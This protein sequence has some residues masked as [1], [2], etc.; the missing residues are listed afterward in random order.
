[1][2]LSIHNLTTRKACRK[3]VIFDDLTHK[4]ANYNRIQTN[5]WMVFSYLGA[6]GQHYPSYGQLAPTELPLPLESDFLFNAYHLNVCT[7]TD[8]L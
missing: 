7:T 5:I 2:V 6:S 1:M 8:Q 4:Y 3:M